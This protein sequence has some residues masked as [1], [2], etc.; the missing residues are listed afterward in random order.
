[1]SLLLDALK[2][3]EQEKLARHPGTAANSDTASAPRA[4]PAAG[5]ASLELAPLASG[6]GAAVHAAPTHRVEAGVHAAQ[7]VFQAKAA[8]PA[9]PE[10]PRNRTVLWATFG[11]IALVG[12]A[13]GA[14]VWYSVKSLTPQYAGTP[15]PRAAP[16]PPPP[17]SGAPLPPPTAMGSIVP[18]AA[19]AIPP[20]S[21]TP[22]AQAPPA[23][24]APPP[25]TPAERIVR[26]AITQPAPAPL[27]LQRAAEGDRRVPAEVAAGYESLRK[28]DL[29]AARRGYQAAL[30]SD[31][32]NVDAHLGIATLAARDVNRPLA[33]EHYRRALDLDPRNA[34]ALAGLAALADFSRPESLEAQLRS[35]LARVP[36]SAALHF[37]LGNLYASQSRW[38]EAQAAYYEAHRLDP[39]SG[40]IAHNLAVS[41]D[42]LGQGRVAAAFYG[43]A[44]E[45]A[46]GRAVQFDPQAVAR[47]LEELR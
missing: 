44:L 34:T 36:D 32:T 2:R 47:R 13:V 35:D 15:R 27:S 7:N 33:A 21:T 16:T 30:A 39:A 1:M 9:A 42:H 3:A 19:S 18:S 5:V 43:R 25:E 11:A 4:A 31:P 14:Y 10:A 38:H 22:S 29:V 40:D 46:R 37:T 45:S 24:P 28:G 8:R 26:E 23:A 20:I 12:I 17:A 41:L 6:T